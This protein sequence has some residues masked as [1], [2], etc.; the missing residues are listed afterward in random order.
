M[1]D[2]DIPIIKKT[3]DLYKTFHE[4]RKIIPKQDRFTIYERTERTMLDIL[5][6][7]L[8]A[9]YAKGSVKAASL[10]KASVKLNILRFF[11][12]TLKETKAIDNKKYIVL[13]TM[14][15]EIG[16]MLGGWIRS[17]GTKY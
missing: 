1:N 5:E 7:F 4:Y 6:S 8:E 14:I 17:A 16:R 9:G 2:I 15:D 10:D 12:R 3:S 13:Q 11:V